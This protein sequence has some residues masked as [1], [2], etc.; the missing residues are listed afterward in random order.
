MNYSSLLHDKI[1]CQASS[2]EISW[3]ETK[4]NENLL[5]LQTAFVAAQRFIRKDIV[6]SVSPVN[7]VSFNNWTLDRLVR[8]YFLTKLDSSDKDSYINAIDTL[9]DT[10]ENNEA[11]A[12]I[13]ALPFLAYPENWMLRATNAVRS[14]VG[15]VFDAIAFENPFPKKH[16]SE[17]AWNQLVLKCIFNDK[18][19]NKIEGISE[20]ANQELADSISYLA[21]ER[22]SARRNIPTQAWRLVSS[23]VNKEILKDIQYLFSSESESEK[24]AAALVCYE[25][26]FQKA[27][28]ELNR[29]ADLKLKAETKAINWELLEN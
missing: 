16:F 12:L 2:K 5:S 21:H 29:H 9:F 17:P 8:V 20:R 22:W 1:L 3:I 24:I 4:A 11:V 10:A 7:S 14:N 27:K 13:S 26:N 18:P 28:E 25:S 15:P 6:Q 19:I 23:F